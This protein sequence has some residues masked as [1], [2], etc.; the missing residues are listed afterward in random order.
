MHRAR[1]RPRVNT[2]T[3][4]IRNTPRHNQSIKRIAAEMDQKSTLITSN[5]K[6]NRPH[7]QD[8]SCSCSRC[9][10]MR[11]SSLTFFFPVYPN[12]HHNQQQLHFGVGGGGGGGGMMGAGGPLSAATGAGACA[13]PG[14][15]G[16]STLM[17]TNCETTLESRP[18]ARPPPADPDH[19]TDRDGH[20]SPPISL[21][22]CVAVTVQ[23]AR[24]GSKRKPISEQN[25]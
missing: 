7:V 1:T 21:S 25:L 24:P 2:R 13:L 11:A 3:T 4:R 17:V 16:Q 18:P 12:Q 8:Q 9:R 5:N 22:L 19:P 20:A 15:Q 23:R 6:R 10:S 14:S